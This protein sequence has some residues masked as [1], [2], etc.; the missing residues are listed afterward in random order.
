MENYLRQY[1]VPGVREEAFEQAKKLGYLTECIDPEKGVYWQWNG[2]L[3]YN[4]DIWNCSTM[5][6]WFKGTV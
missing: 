3:R 1:M 5:D 2:P 4:E 6:V